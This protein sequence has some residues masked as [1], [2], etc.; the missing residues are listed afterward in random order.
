[1]NQPVV[2]RYW[3]LVIRIAW[4]SHFIIRLI[5]Y[6]FIQFQ[7]RALPKHAYKGMDIAFLGQD[8]LGAFMYILKRSANQ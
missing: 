8:S 1:M 2:I 5:A 6:P 4:Q 3:L 7:N